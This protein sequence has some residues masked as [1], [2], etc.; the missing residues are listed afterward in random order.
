MRKERHTPHTLT[1]QITDVS[2]GTAS[3]VTATVHLIFL[4]FFIETPPLYHHKTRFD[5]PPW[6]PL[7]QLGR[8]KIRRRRRALNAAEEEA[9]DAEEERTADRRRA[10]SSSSR[11]A[12]AGAPHKLAVGAAAGEAE[13]AG[14]A[15]ADEQ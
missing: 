6:H 12:G 2:P 14:P 1:L 8:K 10:M 9:V 3:P 7:A 4:S 13:K 11:G 5:T 15:A